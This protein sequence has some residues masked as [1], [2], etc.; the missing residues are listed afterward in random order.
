MN[1][2]ARIACTALLIVA[3]AMLSGCGRGTQA[4]PT[5]QPTSEAPQTPA[6]QPDL[7]DE[8]NQ[9]SYNQWAPAPGYETRQPAKGPHGDEVQ[10]L[11]SPTAE[12]ALAGG[13][14]AWPTD[15][16]IAK[17]IYSGGELAQIAAMKKTTEG[18]YWAEWNADGTPVAEGLAIQ[19]CEGCHAEGTDGTLGVTLQ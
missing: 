6:G 5:G 18:W 8:L 16:V 2:R 13:G 19:P 11:L 14:A 10:I 9:A 7:F 17:D 3:L 1:I 12:E 15:A 4:P